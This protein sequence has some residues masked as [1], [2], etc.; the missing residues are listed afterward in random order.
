MKIV[1]P[2]KVDIA[3]PILFW[4]TSIPAIVVGMQEKDWTI[5]VI[6]FVVFAFIMYLL[7][8]T[9]YTISTD[10]LKVHSGFI[11]NKNIS[12]ATINSIKKTDSLL[13]APASS[14]SDRIEIFYGNSKSIIISPKD[15]QGFV[16]ELLQQNKEI[17]VEL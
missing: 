10:N 9:N 4:I 3:L 16:K 8:D 11:V 12:I 2:S 15:K 6:M 5:M 13:N 7:Y 1:F 17:V 14:L